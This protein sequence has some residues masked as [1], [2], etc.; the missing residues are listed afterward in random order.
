MQHRRML[1]AGAA[2]ALGVSLCFCGSLQAAPKTTI[3]SIRTAGTDPSELAIQP[4]GANQMQAA[5]AL[6][7]TSTPQITPWQQIDVHSGDS[8]SGLF[9]QEGLGA[10]QWRA[11]LAL[12]DKTQVLRNLQ[13]GDTLDI[14]KTPT[15][16]LA[17]LRYRLNSLKTLTVN[18][19]GQGFMA[20]IDQRPTQSREITAEG[21]VGKSLSHSL[22]ANGVPRAVAAQM[23][24][25]YRYRHNL[26]H[27]QAGDKFAI[28]YRATYSDGR[29]LATGPILA[30][31]I[32]TNN[33]N[34][35]AFRARDAHGHYGYYD[36]AGQ[37]Y[38]PA[39]TRKPVAY[40]RISSRFNLHR[41]NPVT[42]HVRP[43]KGVD[44]AAPI[45]TPI[46]A[47][48]KGSIKYAGWA[49]GYGR[50]IEVKNFEGYS[51]RYGHL[52]RFRSDLHAG[53]H[54]SKGEIIGYVGQ[55]GAATGPHL[56]F[57]IRHNG[58]AE[59]PLTVKL[60]SGQPLSHDRLAAY[61]HKIQP[62][63]AK[64]SPAPTTLL[65]KTASTPTQGNQCTHAVSLN[66][67]L[68][69]DPVGAAERPSSGSIFCVVPHQRTNA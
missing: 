52:H 46:H 56:H 34:Y 37:S 18:R 44:M 67:T 32:T 14:R 21:T 20:A 41:L 53:D 8:L 35:K 49:R 4:L 43:H 28:V 33:H 58:V 62:L 9:A 5:T 66:T 48:A 15:G 6:G 2:G 68:A 7:L 19:D 31:S 42:H 1:R 40:T 65:A 36:T 50:L 38:K 23:S 61:T 59:N 27:L 25:I 16:E 11:L 12:G 69:L 45:G 30:A 64:L 51:T 60:P 55:S 47:A 17:E 54:V 39:F 3:G 63:I 13:P 57:E 22:A 24:Q 26:R 10:S 29:Q